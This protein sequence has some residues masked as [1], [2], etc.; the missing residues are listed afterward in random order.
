MGSGRGNVI[1]FVQTERGPVVTKRYLPRRGR[2][3]EAGRRLGTSLRPKSSPGAS[4]RRATERRVLAAW[5]RAGFDVPAELSAQHPRLAGDDV[6]VLEAL[7]GPTLWDR[8][9]EQR[10]RAGRDAWLTRFAR[11]WGRRHAKAFA[12]GDPAFLQEHGSFRHVLLHGERLVTID[13]EQVYLPGAHI[14]SLLLKEVLG[15]LRSVQP[16]DGGR[17][18][19]GDVRT[20]LRAYDDPARLVHAADELL[21][22]RLARRVLHVFESTARTRRKRA[23]AELLRRAAVHE[24]DRRGDAPIPRTLAPDEVGDEGAAAPGR[25]PRS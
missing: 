16:H 21:A 18:L 6:L 24:L 25:P 17:W 15:Y 4:G 5:R 1:A 14:P 3:A 11:T 2:L 19:D 7:D 22:P 10:D 23:L 9:A 20:L 12:S 13:L 8:L